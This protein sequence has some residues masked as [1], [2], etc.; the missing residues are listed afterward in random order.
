MARR[1]PVSAGKRSHEYK[2]VSKSRG[3]PGMDAAVLAEAL[4]SGRHR[5]DVMDDHAVTLTGANACSPSCACPRDDRHQARH[6]HALGGTLGGRL[7]RSSAITNPAC[8][9]TC[10]A[11]PSAHVA[12]RPDRCR[13][14]G[15]Q[16]L[17]HLRS[18]Q[19]L[20]DPGGDPGRVLG[21]VAGLT[22]T[23]VPLTTATPTMSSPSRRSTGALAVPIL[24]HPADT[25]AWPGELD[26]LRRHGYWDPG[27]HRRPAGHPASSPAIQNRPIGAAAAAR[28]PGV[29]TG[30]ICAARGLAAPLQPAD[31][32]QI[33]GGERASFAR[34]RR[35]NDGEH[36]PPAWCIAQRLHLAAGQADDLGEE[37]AGR[38]A[39]LAISHHGGDPVGPVVLRCLRSTGPPRSS[40]SAAATA[41]TSPYSLLRS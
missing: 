40:A 20:V 24:A 1:Q 39:S 36:I 4:D 25:P 23:A 6:H 17:G 8:T 28:R 2:R 29:Q 9:T 16:L 5:R 19:L 15:H 21:A 3:T 38:T 30:Q 34:Q 33:G 11:V 10:R 31:S 35:S 14:A 7:P 32:L 12:L 26:H 37:G 18:R 27:G 41:A 22:V 13:G